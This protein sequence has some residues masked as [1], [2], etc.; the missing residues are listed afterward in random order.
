[1]KRITRITFIVCFGF[2]L[3]TEAQTIGNKEEFIKNFITIFNQRGT[4]FDSLKAKDWEESQATTIKLPGATESYISDNLVYGSLYRGADSLKML[5][6]YKEVKQLLGQI[7]GY[8]N[9]QVKF[10]PFYEDQPFYERFIFADSALFT[11][12][13]SSIGFSKSYNSQDDKTDKE[14]DEGEGEVISKKISDR[15]SFEVLLL[16]NPG[17]AL[18]YFTN[19]GDKLNDPEVKQFVSQVVFASD[20]NWTAIK[21]NKKTEKDLAIYDSKIKLKGFKTEIREWTINKKTNRA[22]LMNKSYSTDEASFKQSADSLVIKFKTAMPAGFCYA[23]SQDEDGIFIEFK[24]VPFQKQPANSPSID[25]IYSA[26]KNKKNVY[27]LDIRI[28]R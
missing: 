2:S 7:A 28:E 22:M 17:D 11:N 19:R 6:F 13:G 9:A 15:N 3:N 27:S 8:Y 5:N 26:V 16:I 20:P 18:C 12:E 10:V 25:F 14:D 4:G 21:I 24:P 23:I 1:M